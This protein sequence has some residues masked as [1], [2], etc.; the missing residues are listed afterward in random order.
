LK[1]QKMRVRKQMVV[2]EPKLRKRPGMLDYESDVDDDWI[3]QYQVDTVEKLRETIRKKFEKEN[4]KRGKEDLKALDAADL[5][6]RL[7]A[8]DTLAAEYAKENKSGT[9]APTSNQTVEKCEAALTK[10]DEKIYTL[11]SQRDMKDSNKETALGT[12]KLNYIDP[13]LSF[14][15]STK[16]GVPIEKLFAKTLRDKFKWASTV[17]DDWEF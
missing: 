14:A 4:E 1:Y 13:R 11:R 3:R 8:A 2:L 12:S 17:D 10:L 7:E 6:G 5:K 16:Y 15:W 9:V